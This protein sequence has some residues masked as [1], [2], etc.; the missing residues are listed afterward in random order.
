MHSLKDGK[1]HL[2][3]ICSNVTAA[4]AVSHHIGAE[5]CLQFYQQ[6][7]SQKFESGQLHFFSFALEDIL[8]S[9]RKLCQL[10][11]SKYCPQS[12]WQKYKMPEQY[13]LSGNFQIT[14]TFFC[15]CFVSK[16]KGQP[17]TILNMMI[18]ELKNR[19][20]FVKLPR[21]LKWLIK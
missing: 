11:E 7:D 20:T 18:L 15:Y 10:G 1:F 21:I 5:I 4:R 14:F 17:G 6:Y 9:I 16:Q 19:D 3:C 2:S 12:K 13:Q 8:P